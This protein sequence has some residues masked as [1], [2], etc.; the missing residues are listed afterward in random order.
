MLLVLPCKPL[1]AGWVLPW[2][3]D[4]LKAQIDEANAKAEEA[5]RATEDSLLIAAISILL[6]IVLGCI[7]LYYFK[8]RTVINK[9]I[10]QEVKVIK[11]EVVVRSPAHEITHGSYTVD[12]LNVI[13]SFS[14]Y[15]PPSIAILL[16]MLVALRQKEWTFKCFFDNNTY[17]VLNEAKLN[18]HARLYVDLCKEFPDNFV[19][20]PTNNRADDYILDYAHSHGTPIISNDRFRDYAATYPWITNPQRRI[21]G[22]CHSNMVQVIPL[23]IQAPLEPDFSSTVTALRNSLLKTNTPVEETK[24]HD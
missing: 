5:Q 7:A 9:V 16:T 17:Y 6:V 23:G 10:K 19:E 13:R 14:P 1:T 24:Q 11:E 20:V 8:N 18:D 4:K 21:S 3:G 15:Q 22:V 2:E 12:G